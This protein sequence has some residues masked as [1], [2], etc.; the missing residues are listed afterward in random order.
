MGLPLY[1][2]MTAA[3]LSAADVLPEKIAYMAC[4]FSPYS[5]GISNVPAQLPAGSLLILNDRTPVSGHD[6]A[7]VAAQLAQA[8][9]RLQPEGLLLDLQR[10]DIPE[11][12]AIIQAVLDGVPCPTAVTAHYAAP[13]DCPVFLDP[14]PPDTG[15]QA[16]LAPWR[17]REIWME[18]AAEGLHITVARDGSHMTALPCPQAQ[19]TDHT[20]DKLCCHYRVEV[21]EDRAEFTLFRTPEDLQALLYRAR[22]QGVSRFAGLYQQLGKF[23]L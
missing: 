20:D 1:L 21:L 4:H 13:F 19:D 10:P 3:E 2:A 15:L 11:T 17:G 16:Y 23:S 22:E 6:P 9:E 5:T 12:P 14:V 18:A 7:A 8:V